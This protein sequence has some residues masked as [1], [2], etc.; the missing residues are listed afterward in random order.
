MRRVYP[1]VELGYGAVRSDSKLSQRHGHT[2]T[3]GATNRKQMDE[4]V[5]HL[6]K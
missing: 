4:V 6:N 5:V 2:T 3:V 1:E